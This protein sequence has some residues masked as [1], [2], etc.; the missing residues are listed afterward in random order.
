MLLLFSGN[1]PVS[2]WLLP[3]PKSKLLTFSYG[4]PSENLHWIPASC[5]L[6]ACLRSW[7][8]L[9]RK[10]TNQA[11]TSKKDSAAH[12]SKQKPLHTEPASDHLYRTLP[13]GS[14]ALTHL[15]SLRVDLLSVDR[16]ISSRMNQVV[17]ASLPVNDEIFETAVTVPIVS[18]FESSI[19]LWLKWPLTDIMLL[20]E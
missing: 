18:A 9:T 4:I 1:T 10:P 13:C 7:D 6:F 14:K 20:I 16:L 11:P 5:H 3:E 12:P 2:Q 8:S 15:P 17:P 19:L